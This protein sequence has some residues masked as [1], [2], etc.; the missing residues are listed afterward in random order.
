MRKYLRQIARERMQKMGI[1]KMNKH[2]YTRDP[3][4]GAVDVQKS[5]FA[6]HWREYLTEESK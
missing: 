2:Q 3:L 1:R 6:Q 5:Y 4:T